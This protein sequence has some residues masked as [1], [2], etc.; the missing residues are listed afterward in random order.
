MR[1]SDRMK[2]DRYDTWAGHRFSDGPPRLVAVKQRG[3]LRNA[4]ALLAR[5]SARRL[6]CGPTPTTSADVAPARRGAEHDQSCRVVHKRR[7]A[8]E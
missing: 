4:L 1:T 8:L 3:E 5:T 7:D 6:P 2:T